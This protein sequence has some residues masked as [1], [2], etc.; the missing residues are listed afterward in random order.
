MNGGTLEANPRRLWSVCFLLAPF[1][2]SVTGFGVGYI[3]A[4]VLFPGEWRGIGLMLATIVCSTGVAYV[5]CLAQDAL[6]EPLRSRIR[7]NAAV[8]NC[9]AD[10]AQFGQIDRAAGWH[11]RRRFAE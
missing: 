9:Q 6:L 4:L 11:T 7:G 3:I 8:S 1:A 10:R 5:I 2:E